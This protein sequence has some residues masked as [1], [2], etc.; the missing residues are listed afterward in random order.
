MKISLCKERD[1]QRL[2][3][4][5]LQWR[6]DIYYIRNNS[7]AGKFHRP[8][9]SEGWVRNNKKG[10]PDLILCKDGE[11]IGCEIKTQAGRQSDYQKQAELEIKKAGGK[12]YIIRSLEEFIE[13]IS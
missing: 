8:D 9:G 6:K 4:N 10:A 13:K 7:V 12:Y 2:I 5:Y 11:W 1:I 3:I